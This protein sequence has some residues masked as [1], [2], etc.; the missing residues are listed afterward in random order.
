MKIKNILYLFLLTNIT[1]PYIFTM[2]EPKTGRPYEEIKIFFDLNPDIFEALKEFHRLEKSEKLILPVEL[3]DMIIEAIRSDK[4]G[5]ALLNAIKN[6]NIDEVNRLLKK[7]YININVQGEY[8]ITPLMEAVRKRRS[9][10]KECVEIVKILLEK[11]ANLD[12]Q[13]SY[14]STA[15]HY[16]VNMNKPEIVQMLLEKGANPNMQNKDGETALHRASVAQP[17]IVKMLLEKGA[18]PNLQDKLG[19]AALYWA[20]RMAN[21][22][23]VQMLLEKG[24]NPNLKNIKGY[25]VFNVARGY[26]C[27]ANIVQM[28]NDALKKR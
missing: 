21:S 23:I 2:E 1:V 28:L 17:E 9:E 12:L 16:A 5:L 10:A 4:N 27:D 8:G 18:N 6:S 22:E 3:R 13:D 14:G 24:A 19:W 15:L 20:V 7:P 26:Y 11:G 25:T